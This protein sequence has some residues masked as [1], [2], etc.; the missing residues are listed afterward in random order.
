MQATMPTLLVRVISLKRSIERR[1]RIEQQLKNFFLEWEFLDAVDG[2]ALKGLPKSYDQAKVRRLQGH[3]LTSGE[4]GCYLSHLKAWELCVK[5]KT[6]ILVFEDDFILGLT[7][8]AIVTDLMNNCNLWGVVRLS[9]IHETQDSAIK[10]NALYRLSLNQ[11]DPCGTACYLIQP[12]AAQ[13]LINH[14]AEIYEAVDHFIE[15]FSKHGVRIYAAKPYPVGLSN[16]KSTIVDRNDKQSVKGSKK[17]VR[18]M[19]RAWDRL[20]SQSPWFPKP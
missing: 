12:E 2:F 17:L 11:G 7:I 13:I 18:S 19:Y 1:E 15:H 5:E 16:S 9:G 6:P 3:D 14:S 10:E 8:K 20:T 4:I